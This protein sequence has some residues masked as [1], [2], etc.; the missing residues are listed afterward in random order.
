LQ[1]AE[2][3]S[4]TDAAAHPPDDLGPLPATEDLP[5]ATSAGEIQVGFFDKREKIIRLLWTFVQATLFRWSFKRA[6]NWRAF[7]LRRFGATIG[8][9]PLIR[10]TIHV[11]VPWNLTAGDDLKLGDN[12]IVYNLGPLTIGDRTRVSQ[13]SHLCGG[14]H[15]HT[16]S[17]LPLH[18]VPIR[19]GSDVWICTDCYV[20]GGVVI[21]NGVM[22][23]ARS[24]VYKDLPAWHICV[25]SPA[26][27]V[28]RRA[29]RRIEKNAARPPE[30]SP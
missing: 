16:R 29:F 8:R 28:K 9:N 21:G 4:V 11:E 7:L 2:V 25:G 20:G 27:A 24:N 12:V 10:R 30:T 19:I 13:L 5:T 6:D 14:S 18:R 15:D 22:V 17:D 3:R 1:L 26:R 23:G